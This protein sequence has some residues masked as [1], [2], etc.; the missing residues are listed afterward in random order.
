MSK[1]AVF[2]SED[3]LG[4]KASPYHPENKNRLISIHKAFKKV[5]FYD[6]EIIEPRV[7]KLKELELVHTKEHIENVKRASQA[8]GY[9]DPDTYTSPGSYNAALKAAGS[10]MQATQLIQEKELSRAFCLVRPPGHHALANQ[11]MGFCLFNNVAL[12]AAWLVH[13]HNKKVAILDFDAHH[14]NGTQSI[15]FESDKVLY[16][17]WHQ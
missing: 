13:N 8:S 1:L 14:G 11:T 4:H 5:D 3:F 15:F 12:G 9:L 10:L 7:A 17:S 16:C 2:Y 6:A